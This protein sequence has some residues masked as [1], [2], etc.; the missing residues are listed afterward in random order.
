[1]SASATG[2]FSISATVTAGPC[3][4]D[5]SSSV[6]DFGDI[7]ARDITGKGNYK[8][9]SLTLSKCPAGT[10]SV[11]A[12]FGGTPDSVAPEWYYKNTG[13]ARGIG[14][15]LASAGGD[16]GMGNG[17]TMKST[18]GSDRKAIFN[19]STRINKEG[20]PAPGTVLTTITVT[21]TYA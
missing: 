11:T 3:V 17:K 4:V 14:I 16:I 21:Y 20:T 12:T 19:L 15:E 2:N 13:T 7:F 18:V 9:F 1:M 10:S 8:K 5:S 6:Q